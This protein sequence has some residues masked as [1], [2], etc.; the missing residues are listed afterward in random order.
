MHKFIYVIFLICIISACSGGLLENRKYNILQESFD[1][2]GDFVAAFDDFN[3]DEIKDTS[4]NKNVLHYN[5]KSKKPFRTDE[6]GNWYYRWSLTVETFNSDDEAVDSY[7]KLVK[8]FREY[9]VDD[10]M[11]LKGYNSRT[12]I[13]ENYIYTISAG[14]KEGRYVQTW[15]DK[16]LLVILKSNPPEKNTVLETGCGGGYVIK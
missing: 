5:F 10:D 4:D 1:I 11:T 12:I 13:C 2:D 14:C 8:E 16:L 3:Y 6:E 9:G 15:F 7:N